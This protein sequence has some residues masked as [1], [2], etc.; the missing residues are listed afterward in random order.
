MARIEFDASQERVE[1]L[2]QTLGTVELTVD[3][4]S[5]SRIELEDEFG[6]SIEFEGKKLKWDDDDG[7]VAGK[8]DE[9][10]V[11]DA[12]GDVVNI[13]DFNVSAKVVQAA[14]EAGGLDGVSTVLQKGADE[15]KGSDGDDWL[16]GLRG[17]DIIKGGKG[18]DFLLGGRGD[19][20]L[21]GG[22]GSDYFVFE[23]KAGTD[24]VKDFKV[25]GNNNDFIAVDADLLGTATWERDGK[26]LVIT[27]EDAGSIELK[28]VKPGEF[29]EDFIVALPEPEPA[30]I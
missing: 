21:V 3:R 8:I 17:D 5:K 28:G 4:E 6:N 22:Q 25:D 15:I 18:E 24:L 29:N 13:K 7:L 10:T 12:D 14:F 23:A 20:V 1:A 2:W 9:I 11:R 26:N 30:M 16:T 27:F 19:D